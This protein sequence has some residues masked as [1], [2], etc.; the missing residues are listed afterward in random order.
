M[1]RP[2]S[3]VVMTS[4]ICPGNVPLLRMTNHHDRLVWT[5]CSLIQWIRDPAVSTIV[6]CDNTATSLQLQPIVDE[7]HRFHTDLELMTC[8]SSGAAEV[9]G[10]GAGEGE[11]MRHVLSHSTLLRQYKSFWKITAKMYVSNFGELAAIHADDKAVFRYPAWSFR[12][13]WRP[14]RDGAWFASRA[15]VKSRLKHH[16]RTVM[17]RFDEDINISTRFYRTSVAYFNAHLIDAHSKVNDH[18]GFFLEH[19]YARPVLQHGYVQMAHTPHI[20]GRSGT[21]G[22]AIDRG[23]PEDQ[24]SHAEELA[25]GCQIE[26]QLD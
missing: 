17:R 9:Y 7:A 10:K 13:T 4:A 21:F 8:S 16:V 5:I 15:W 11:I 3:C 23:F 6:L 14:D 24:L 20:V 19:A 26:R 22:G 25:A 2:G 1:E 18:K 12:Y